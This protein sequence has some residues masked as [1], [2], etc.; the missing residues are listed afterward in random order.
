MQNWRENE[1]QDNVGKITRRTG[2]TV[3]HTVT[4]RMLGKITH[5]TRGTIFHT[6]TKRHDHEQCF[7][8]HNVNYLIHTVSKLIPVTILSTSFFLHKA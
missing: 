1:N 4:K 2:G 5:R 7:M 6:A 3:F 8:V